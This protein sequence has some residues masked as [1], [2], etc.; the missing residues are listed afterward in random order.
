[1]KILEVGLNAERNSVVCMPETAIVRRHTP[2]FIPE[3]SVEWRL[4]VLLAVTIERL[5]KCIASR[6]ASRYWEFPRLLLKAEYEGM[7]VNGIDGTLLLSDPVDLSDKVEFL[8]ESLPR[9]G[10]EPSLLFNCSFEVEMT[11]EV[12]GEAIETASRF[13]TVHT[14]DLI[15]VPFDKS[16]SIPVIPETKLTV[17]RNNNVIL[18]HKIK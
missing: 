5:G 7:S 8:V 11:D 17:Y 4:R 18:N 1:M 2:F 14:G 16:V 12:I 13:F 10:M 3:M 15:A 9:N 6:F